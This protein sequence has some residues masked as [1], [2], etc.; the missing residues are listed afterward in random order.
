MNDIGGMTVDEYLNLLGEKYERLQSETTNRH[1][2]VS[3][4]IDKGERLCIN[5]NV[6]NRQ[7]KQ[8]RVK[9]IF[10]SST[11][12]EFLD[13]YFEPGLHVI[14]GSAGVGKSLAGEVL[15]R[16]KV[17]RHAIFEHIRDVDPK[18]IA[19]DLRGMEAKIQQVINDGYGFVDSLR[20]L[21]MIAS[22]YPAI[23]QGVS[24]SI[25]V[26]SQWLSIVCS[27]TNTVMFAVVSTERTQESIQELYFDYLKGGPVSC[28]LLTGRGQG[29][30]HRKYKEREVDIAFELNLEG[31]GLQKEQYVQEKELPLF[32]RLKSEIT[33]RSKHAK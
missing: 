20:L 30:G 1:D 26:F 6:G 24:S 5:T 32:S 16:R 15:Y 2:Q 13:G 29:I 19:I 7:P 31:T 14:F 8:I 9:D 33:I 21:P 12:E 10:T 3:F 4:K 25:F 11:H 28:W 27:Q 18:D 17:P 22:G 23:L